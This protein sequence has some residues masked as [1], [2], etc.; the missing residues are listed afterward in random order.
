M[1]AGTYRWIAPIVLLVVVAAGAVTSP[2]RSVVLFRA[3]FDKG[4]PEVGQISNFSLVGGL[5]IEPDLVDGGYLLLY[6]NSGLQFPAPLFVYGS[7][8]Q[9]VKVMTGTLTCTL[10]MAV[11]KQDSPFNVGIVVDNAAS[12][13]IPATGSDDEG[14]LFAGDRKTTQTVVTH[15]P[16]DVTLT[17]FRNRPNENWN[18]SARFDSDPQSNV[19]PSGSGFEITG[20]LDGTANLGVVGIGSCKPYAAESLGIMT[21]DDLTVLYDF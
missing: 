18:V 13:F 12:D 7:F 17:I 14:N 15:R 10:E 8:D 9:A 20:V 11:G 4:V 21:V 16:M 6:D 3:S 2:G 19:G 1:K 5:S